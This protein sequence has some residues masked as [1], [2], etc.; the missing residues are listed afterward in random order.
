MDFT[1]KNVWRLIL[2]ILVIGFLIYTN[3]GSKG[4]FVPDPSFSN[5]SETLG[6]NTISCQF[7]VISDFSLE[8]TAKKISYNSSENSLPI[9]IVF[10]GL[11][12]KSPILKGNNGEDPLV[13]L[14]NTDSKITMVSSN[15][16]GD[17]FLYKIYKDAKVATWHKSY[18]LFG[19][20]YAMLS[21]G[22]CY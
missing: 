1:K 6:I 16:F 18:D 3:K 15:A 8:A 22:Y 2:V 5:Y 14:S 17:I 19:N 13:I 9:D 4:H 11:D 12:T 21:M 10:S 7:K 20:P